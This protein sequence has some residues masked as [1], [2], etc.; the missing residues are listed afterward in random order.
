MMSLTCHGVLMAADHA[1][2]S[3]PPL[4]GGKNQFSPNL[5]RTP[6]VPNQRNLSA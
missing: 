3:Q 4:T 5:G 1:T 2:D 6:E